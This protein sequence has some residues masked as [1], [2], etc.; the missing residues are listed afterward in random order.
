MLCAKKIMRFPGNIIIAVDE[1]L[2]KPIIACA[3]NYAIWGG[4][5]HG[6]GVIIID[7][8]SNN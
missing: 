8:L 3:P 7:S 2:Q 6:L 4:I 5:T 1:L